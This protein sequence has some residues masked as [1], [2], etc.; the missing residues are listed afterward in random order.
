M[1]QLVI[2]EMLDKLGFDADIT[3]TGSDGL[4]AAGHQPY[5]AVMVDL[6]LPD[7]D[8]DQ[9]IEQ[10]R[11]KHPKLPVMAMSAHADQQTIDHAMAAGAS[12]FLAKPFRRGAMAEILARVLG[13]S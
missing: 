5:A 3:E 8:G 9:V 10:L 1:N 4:E 12:Q 13:K 6:R 11:D 2:H 7:M